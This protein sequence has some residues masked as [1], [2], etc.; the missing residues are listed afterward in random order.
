MNTLLVLPAVGVVYLQ[1]LG[2]EKA[3]RQAII[4]AQIQVHDCA[5]RCLMFAH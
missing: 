2:R 1:A 5:N 4:M 3:L